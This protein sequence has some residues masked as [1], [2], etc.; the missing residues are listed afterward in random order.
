MTNNSIC[1]IATP[2]GVGA[3]SVIR[4]S[5]SD[6]I[7]LLNKV[8]KGK[9]LNKCLPNT[10]N[11]GYIIDGSDI[12]DEVMV[13][14]FHG[15]KSFTGENSCEI[16]CHGGIYNTNRVLEV[17][18]KNGFTLAEP[19]EFSK[20]AFLNGRIDLSQSEAIMDIIS[21]SNELALKASIHSLRKGTTNLVRSLREKLL[22]LIAKI[23]VNIDYPEYDDAVFMTNEIIEPVLKSLIK[24]MEDVLAHSK[25]GVMA[26]NGVKTAIV[27]RPNVGKSS[28]LN[29]LLEEEKAIVTDIA[30]TTRDLIEGTLSL[31]NVTLKLIDTAGIRKSTDVVEQIGIE[32][33]KKAI[34]DA[35]VVM[36]VLDSSS[37]LQDDDYELLKLTEDKKRIVIY[38]KTDLPL[39]IN[40]DIPHINISAL[41]QEGVQVLEK[42]LLDLTKINEFNANDNNYLSNTRHVALMNDALKSLYSAL[43]SCEAYVDVDMIEIDIKDAWLNLG[44]IIGD[45]SPDLLINEL[46]S[47]FCLGK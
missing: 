18:L 13:S 26:V 5:G 12:I 33:S 16:S 43:N 2:Y 15:P 47:K 24:E 44:K 39:K 20:R 10:I 34:E 35:E 3:I 6:S 40:I 1:A 8:F 9:N 19:G 7:E 23:E 31:G 28:L 11:Y 21:S 36:L 17:L 30:G 29:M 27:G 4:T 37:P 41:K 45:D 22:D 46:F 42:A 14:V 38:N 25:I 32:R